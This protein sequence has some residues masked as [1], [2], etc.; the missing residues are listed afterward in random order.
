[1][2][3]IVNP[4]LLHGWEVLAATEPA[5]VGWLAEAALVQAAVGVP[6]AAVVPGAWAVATDKT[7]RGVFVRLE[8]IA[9]VGARGNGGDGAN[10]QP[11]VSVQVDTLVSSRCGAEY[12][13]GCPRIPAV[14]ASSGA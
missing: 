1:M 10:S 7:P 2:I 14:S 5:T 13:P 6:A 3:C 9:S 8:R 11:P 4:F 12:P